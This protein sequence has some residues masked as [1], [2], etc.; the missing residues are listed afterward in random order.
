[1]ATPMFLLPPPSGEGWGGGRTWYALRHP[2]LSLPI[3]GRG[4]E[5]RKS[6]RGMTLIELLLVLA[7]LTVI[8]SMVVP[9]FTGSFSSIRLRRAGDKVLTSWSAARARAIESGEVMQFSFTPES[10]TYQV[11]PWAGVVE[12]DTLGGAAT[13]SS[14]YGTATAP[15]TTATTVKTG[16]A[17][18]AEDAA[19][20]PEQIVFHRGELLVEDAITGERAVAP[21]QSARDAQSTAILFF[22]DG[23]SSDASVV[24]A[25]DRRQY[26]RLMLRG[27][28]GVGRA[29]NVLTRDEL[30]RSE[31][32]R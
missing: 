25:N 22:P 9:V 5:V 26:V 10:G 20:L 13:S 21:M 16:D 15:A 23:T 19:S 7:L 31:R 18:Q 4:P 17:D 12:D 2:S 11:E 6:R 27:L 29:S 1:L 24:I 14:S 8:G 28:T 32:R 30:Q 3:K